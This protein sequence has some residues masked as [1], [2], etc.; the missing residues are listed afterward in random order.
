MIDFAFAV[1]QV[2]LYENSKNEYNS[3]SKGKATFETTWFNCSLPLLPQFIFEK[4]YEVPN[5]KSWPYK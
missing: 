5:V 2:D 3:S 4:A 1:K